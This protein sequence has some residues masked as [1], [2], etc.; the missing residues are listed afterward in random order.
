MKLLGDTGCP[1]G[2][3]GTHWDNQSISRWSWAES[4]RQFIIQAS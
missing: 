4:T 1:L 2:E 3:V